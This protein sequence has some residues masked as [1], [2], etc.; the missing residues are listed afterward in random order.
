MA[1][2]L[3]KVVSAAVV[4]NIIEVYDMSIYGY[5]AA[6][7]AMNFF[8]NHNSMVGLVNTFAVFFLGFLAR[9]LGSILFGYI[10]DRRGRKAALVLSVLL[11]AAATC[12]IGL[13]PT[14]HSIG[15]MAAVLLVIL[16]LF[17][18]FSVGGEYLGSS[19]FL[20]E[21]APEKHRGLF[22]GFAM[23]SGNAGM[24]VA[25]AAAWTVTYFIPQQE[26]IK[27]GWR[28]PFVAAFIG[29]GVGLWLRLRASETKAFQEVQRHNTR[30]SHPLVESFVYFRRALISIVGLTWLG[31]VATYLLVVFMPTFMSSVLH[32][33]FHDAIT[34]NL[35]SVISLLIWI[36]VAGM[37]SDRFGRRIMMA[38]GAL[39]L[40]LGILPY[41]E[42]LMMNQ[43]W[44]AYV[45]QS[46]IMI[47]LGIYCG[48]T[49]TC[50]VEMVPP[51]VRFSATTFAYNIGA[52]IFGG[53]TPL[54]AI[55][56]IHKTALP[57]SPGYYL[58]FCGLF[59][60]VAIYHMDETAKSKLK[61]I[62]IV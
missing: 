41:Y 4:G 13:L 45:A 60:L 32:Y 1:K 33:S 59:S 28:I 50:M 19:I 35:V 30:L 3:S 25:A 58:I 31:V 42:L 40:M 21:H 37:L 15:P 43:L 52:A 39:G 14:Y 10:G 47:P 26:I 49:P 6:F 55:W 12:A 7:I 62:G 2:A 22:G 24:L 11:M 38:I 29:G 34:I 44:L 20:V 48:V 8:P 27:Y 53:T 9:P 46:A 17:Q 18:G 16:R 23:L 51:H 5:L 61:P 56:L 57:L 54:I 36:P